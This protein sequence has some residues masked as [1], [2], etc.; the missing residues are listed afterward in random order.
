MGDMPPGGGG[1]G[2]GPGFGGFP[3]TGFRPAGGGGGGVHHMSPEEAQEFFSHFFGGS[4]PFGG[5]FGFS[6]S[7]NGGRR[8]GR[9]PGSADIFSSIGGGMP[10]IQIGGG[11]PGMQMGGGMPGMHMGGGM[12]FDSYAQQGRPQAKRYDAIPPGTM[13]SLKGL[14]KRPDRNGDRGEIQEFDPSTGRYVVVLED[15]EETMSVKPAN[16]LQHVHVRLHGIES[17][18]DLNGKTGTILAWNASKERYNVYVVALS[19]VVSVKPGNVIL[20]KDTVGQIIGLVS[21]PELNGKWGTIK[22]WIRDSN[23]YEVQ[24]SANQVVRVKMENIRV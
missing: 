2:G 15:S 13:V 8:R 10:G 23:R 7:M 11:M 24:L 14:I 5:G 21:K 6:S 22:E 16:L 20:D 9:P 17:Q 4:D 12:P 18:Q 1:G 19:K 3:S